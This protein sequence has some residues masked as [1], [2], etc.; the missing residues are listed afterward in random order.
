VLYSQ[1]NVV[2][3]VL[4]WRLFIDSHGATAAALGSIMIVL[5]V[6]VVA[7]LRRQ[8]APRHGEG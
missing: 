2:L 6:P 1:E 7:L 3:S 8:L 5:V 4:L